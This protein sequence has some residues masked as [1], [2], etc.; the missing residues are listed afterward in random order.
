MRRPRRRQ[1]LQRARSGTAIL[2]AL[3]GFACASVDIQRLDPVV[4]PSRPASEV[5]VL[6]ELPA[7]PH[8]LLARIEVRD[9]GRGR[10]A[11]ALRE[12]L[13]G[14]AA[15]LGA[16]AVVF[17]DPANRRSIGGAPG[18][19]GLYDDLVVAGIAIAHGSPE[20]PVPADR[21]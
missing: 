16:D 3:A 12:E 21:R 11:R 17:E 5:A 19:I 1:A 14:A 18:P 8:R 10:S 9:R 4:R 2:C 15:E 20:Q 6:E 13:L 7:G